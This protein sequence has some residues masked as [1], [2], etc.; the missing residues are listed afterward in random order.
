MA[1]MDRT[2]PPLWWCPRALHGLVGPRHARDANERCP[3]ADM[4]FMRRYG[5]SR[6]QLFLRWY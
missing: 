4:A 1:G 2:A 6:L 3:M 5:K